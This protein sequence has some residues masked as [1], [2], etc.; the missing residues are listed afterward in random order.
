MQATRQ[1][2][3]RDPLGAQTP[4]RWG[5][6][7]QVGLKKR[8]PLQP[9][10]VFQLQ[11]F[12]PLFAWLRN[13][14]G[15]GGVW[16]CVFV[17]GGRLELTTLRGFELFS[18]CASFF[19]FFPPALMCSCYSL[20]PPPTSCQWERKRESAKERPG[21]RQGERVRGYGGGGGGSKHNH[22][23]PAARW[24]EK[25]C[26]EEKGGG[27]RDRWL[28]RGDMS[29]KAENVLMWEWGLWKNKD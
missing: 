6:D 13:A 10:D 29:T 8:A 7:H 1:L 11:Q 26:A 20:L 15:W 17:G 28:G 14:R 22:S 5:W 25:V 12:S 18:L 19:F 21:E 4:A 2:L 9:P 3:Y 23:T 27:D 24:R 16:G